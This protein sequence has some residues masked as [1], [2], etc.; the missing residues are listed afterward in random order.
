MRRLLRPRG[1]RRCGPHETRQGVK[2]FALVD[3]HG[4]LLS[5]ST[6]AMN[7]HEVILVQLSF[8]FY[9]LEAKPEHLI[10]NCAYDRDNLSND[11]TQDG[12]SL[13][14]PHRSTRKLKTKDGLHLCCSQRRGLVERFS[15]WLYVAPVEVSPIDPLGVLSLQL[16]WLCAAR[17]HHEAPQTFSRQVRERSR[18]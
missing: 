6:H 5:V 4:P 10:G 16:P 2:I 13:I 7:H 9:M 1:W 14:A 3:R 8:D 15:A 17:V 12:V 18:G 11:L